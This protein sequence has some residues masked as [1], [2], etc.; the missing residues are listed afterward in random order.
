MVQLAWQFPTRFILAVRNRI[1]KR[2]PVSMAVQA[3]WLRKLFPEGKTAMSRNSVSW[4][5]KVSPGDYTRTYSIQMLYK[6]DSSPEVWVC[7]PNLKE[8]AGDRRL[9]HVYD[10]KT[11]L[12][13]LYL[14]NCG[15]WSHDKVL[16]Q[17]VLPWACL[18]L[19]YFELWLVTNE[20]HGRGEHP[21]SKQ[22]KKTHHATLALA[23]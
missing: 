15:F 3:L 22:K 19:H 4:R 23:A 7:D 2:P 11:Q 1:P 10:E 12:L 8:L 9:P 14:P 6:Q 13:C 21:H 5:G 16:A 17:T 20:W 18:W